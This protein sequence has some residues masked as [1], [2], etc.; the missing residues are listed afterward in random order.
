MTDG[1]DLIVK[2]T[3]NFAYVSGYQK[4]YAPS[5]IAWKHF[6]A[7]KS[8][9]QGNDRLERGIQM[10]NEGRNEMREQLRQAGL[11]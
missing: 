10:F 2:A 11:L 5:D 3:G 7:N 9:E 8:M 1:M 4:G 6:E